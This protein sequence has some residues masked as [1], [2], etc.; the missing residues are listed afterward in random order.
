MKEYSCKKVTLHK[1]FNI[2]FKNRL[3]MASE[4]LQALPSD[5]CF[6]RMIP[7]SLKM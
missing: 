7:V 2:L 3:A 4:V 5:I 1:K 6:A